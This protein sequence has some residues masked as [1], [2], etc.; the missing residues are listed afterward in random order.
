MIID[1]QKIEVA[2]NSINC[3]ES[4]FSAFR[5]RS[6]PFLRKFPQYFTASNPNYNVACIYKSCDPI[7][8]AF[9]SRL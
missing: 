4:P 3:A 5:F 9:S 2:T 7:S 8:I 6:F 1:Y